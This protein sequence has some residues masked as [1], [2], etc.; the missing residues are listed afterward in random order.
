MIKYKL[1]HNAAVRS[2]LFTEV[3][4]GILT[5]IILL[6][7]IFFLLE[8]RLSPTKLFIGLLALTHLMMLII[9]GIIATDIFMPWKSFWNT[10][11][12]KSLVYLYRLVRG[13]SV[14]VTCLLSVLQAI[15]LSPRSSCLAKFKRTS[16]HPSL[17]AL[18]VLWVLY[19][20]VSSH[21]FIS[22]IATPNLT[23]DSLIYVTESCSVLPISY[24]LRQVFSSL[25][26]FREFLL[27]GLTFLSNGYMVL[28][29]CRHK[30]R[31]QHLHSASISLKASPEQ[32][33]TRTILMLTSFFLVMSILDYSISASRIMWNNDPVLYYVIVLVDHS[34]A[35]VSPLVLMSTD[36]RVI[37][38]VRTVWG[39]TVNVYSGMDIVSK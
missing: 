22:I 36:K 13:L 7:H 25:L 35:A 26:T 34:Y 37:I 1:Y 10:I 17:C 2:T 32:R 5:N 18:V 19:M 38:F 15:T 39:R 4:I 6:F 33:A 16:P 12:C 27:M 31:S 24:T 8:H 3:A 9:M 14:C 11:M 20:S 29:L 23:S 28:L 30:R 21:I